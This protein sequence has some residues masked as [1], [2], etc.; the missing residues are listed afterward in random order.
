VFGFLFLFSSGGVRGII[1]ANSSLDVVLHDSYFVVSHF[2]YV[3]SIGRVFGIFL[4]LCIYHPLI[5]GFV[6]SDLL[7]YVVF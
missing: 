1:L 4:G 3:L 7:M 6:F 5:T 2:H